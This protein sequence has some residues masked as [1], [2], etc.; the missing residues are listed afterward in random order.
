VITSIASASSNTAAATN[1]NS[2]TAS[3]FASLQIVTASCHGVLNTQFIAPSPKP[4]WFDDLNGKLDA[5]KVLA[6]Q[7][8]DDIAPKLTASIP[9][10][11]IDY[12]TT[13]TA[14]TDQIVDLLNKNP[15][16][17]G[18][19][20]PVVQQVFALI[21]ALHD[22][23]E[24]IITDVIGT[25]EQLKIWG[26][27]MQKSHD[28]LFA[29]AANIQSLQVDLQADIG[30]MNA[31]IQGLRA[32][33]DAENKAIVAG[34]LAIGVGLFALVVG[35]ALAPVTGGASLIVSGI[36]GAAI[37]G[38]AVTW[39]VMQ[40]KI[41]GQFDEIAEDQNKISDDKRQ[42]VAL[43]GLSLAANSAISSIATATSA[44]SDVKVMWTMFQ[45]EL[46]GT[47]DKLEK[48]DENLS[49]IVNKAYII[50]AQNEWN[51]AVQFAQQL[52][53]MTV[54]VEQKTL[55]MAA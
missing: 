38:G 20:N 42:L 34:A 4:S 31:A 36:G 2:S 39:G 43:Q 30:K 9:S 14:L 41:N 3:G 5:A 33:I 45:N 26:D 6:N 24:T 11:V 22:E 23:I 27:A 16:A 28:D 15:T 50:A 10:H 17:K 47:M 52:S 40:A 12:G 48:T 13:Y 35:I 25:Q 8:I 55:P 29:G 46:Q 7:W 54:P 1:T 49:A 37:I 32:Q 21:S 19:D 44:L 53:G 18:K 51:L